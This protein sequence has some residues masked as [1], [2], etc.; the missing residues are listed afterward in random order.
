MAERSPVAAGIVAPMPAR[1]TLVGGGS[2]HWTPKLMVDFANTPV[3]HDTEVVLSRPVGARI[4]GA[5]P[6]MAPFTVSRIS[7]TGVLWCRF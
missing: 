5:R 2:T 7:E 6:P 3:L 1:I 4:A